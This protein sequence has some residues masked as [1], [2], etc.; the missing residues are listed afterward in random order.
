MLSL[1]RGL[2]AGLL[3]AGVTALGT[4]P[5]DAAA[6][7]KKEDLTDRIVAVAT[8]DGLSLKGYWFQGNALDKQP[9][10]AVMMFPAPGGKIT[11][12]W[13]DL[14]KA[15]S[16]KNFSV[17][18]FDWRGCGLNGPDGV[19]A[20]TRIFAD[21]DQFWKE[22]Y[23]A[24]LLKSYRPTIE[25]KG[26]DWKFLVAAS[27]TQGRYRDFFF[28]DL[29]AARFFL[30]KQSDAGKCNTNRTWVVSEKDGA[31]VGLAFIAAEFQR[32]T[33]YKP[34]TNLFD[35]SMQFKASGKDY[36]G[37]MAMS[38]DGAG[39]YMNTTASMVYRNALP[40]VGANELVKEALTH[41]EDRLALVLMHTKAEKSTASKALIASTRV[42][43]N[44]DAAMK[45]KFK[46]LKEFDVKAKKPVAG[47]DLIE[48]MDSFG[49]KAFVVDAMVG[50]SKAQPF[51]K[52][53]TTRDASKMVYPPRFPV[54]QFSRK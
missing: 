37:L 34:D 33:I 19:G 6:Q 49:A 53:P 25:K 7:A 43:T 35:T 45:T 38:Y 26:L 27:N 21:Q 10:D 39:S 28:N 44:D 40:R 2:L 15:L 17:L 8:S 9:P 24:V 42:P 11:D 12:A 48:P 41:L 20:G 32:N 14:A 51:G 52:D 23:N 50:I 31:H 29:L 22:G 13:V 18:L 30:D 3:V 1:H 47:I 46:Y 54:E 36:A 16:E 4:F 5:T